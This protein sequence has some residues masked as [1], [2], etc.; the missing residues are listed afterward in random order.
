MHDEQRGRVPLSVVLPVVH[1]IAAGSAV[2]GDEPPGAAGPMDRC[3]DVADSAVGHNA[4]SG[5]DGGDSH[6]GTAASS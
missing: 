3:R 5:V 1:R 4:G 6:R 2:Q